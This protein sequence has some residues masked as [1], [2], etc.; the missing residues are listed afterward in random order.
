MDSLQ[1]FNKNCWYLNSDSCKHEC[2]N[3]VKF[4]I[5]KIAMQDSGVPESLHHPIPLKP[6]PCDIDKFKRLA[7]IK[8]NMDDFVCKGKNLYLCSVNTGNG[9]T[10]WAIKLMYKYFSLTWE[11]GIAVRALFINTVE[12]LLKLKD[13]NNPISAQ[14][15]ELIINV[16]LVIWDDIAITGISSWDYMQLYVL[17]NER[18]MRGLANIYTSNCTTLEQLENFVGNKI[19]SRIWTRDTE[20]IELEGEDRR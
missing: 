19:A 7:E 4:K 2:G 13:F 11:D 9:K 6:S 18:S 20:I 5:M 10:S 14:Y 15:R 12:L 1:S 16:P 8:N 3:C 17:L